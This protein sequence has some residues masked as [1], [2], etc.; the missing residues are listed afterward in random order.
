MSTTEEREEY[1]ETHN[2][3]GSSTN[4]AT[5]SDS[6]SGLTSELLTK[7]LLLL[8]KFEE[9]LRGA[10]AGV[11]PMLSIDDTGAGSVN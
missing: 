9:F 7:D 4:A 6:S 8:K 3:I 2:R 11:T 5:V 10:T 1:E